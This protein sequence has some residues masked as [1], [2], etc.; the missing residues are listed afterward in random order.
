MTLNNG[1]NGQKRPKTYQ[2][3][4]PFPDLTVENNLGKLNMAEKH[5][6][7]PF[8][9]SKNKFEILEFEIIKNS[10]L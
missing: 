10:T 1:K 8:T 5:I 7:R 9:S 2:Y 4:K 3:L 6:K